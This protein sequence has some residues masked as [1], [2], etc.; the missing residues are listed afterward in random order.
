MTVTQRERYAELNAL[1]NRVEFQ[2]THTHSGPGRRMRDLQV[3]RTGMER[4]AWVDGKVGKEEEPA[5]VQEP[6]GQATSRPA[7]LM[8]CSPQGHFLLH[9]F[10]TFINWIP[11]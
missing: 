6:H 2:R 3:D 5:C 11:L 1:G 9:C 4:L 10:P 7:G 8:H